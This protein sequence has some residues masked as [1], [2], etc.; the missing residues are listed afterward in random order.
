[1]AS[2][3]PTKRFPCGAAEKQTKLLHINN[4]AVRSGFYNF[5]DLLPGAA[6]LEDLHHGHAVAA[7]KPEACVLGD[8]VTHRML[9]NDL[10][11]VTRRRREDVEHDLLHH[12]RQLAQLTGRPAGLNVDSNQRHAVL[13]SITIGG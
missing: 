5:V 1:V 4:V 3:T 2:R 10:V 12:I 7:L 13:L 6:L 8:D 11:P 9:S